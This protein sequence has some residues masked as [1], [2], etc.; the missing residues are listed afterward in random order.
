MILI[1]GTTN[2]CEFANATDGSKH[3]IVLEFTAEEGIVETCFRKL[4]IKTDHDGRN[5]IFVPW[6]AFIV[7]RGVRENHEPAVVPL[8][9]TSQ[10]ER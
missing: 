7:N 5:E 4:R 8:A 9:P 10:G 3:R 1:K 6:S 2:S